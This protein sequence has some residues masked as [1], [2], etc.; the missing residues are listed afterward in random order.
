MVKISVIIP[1]YNNEKYLKEC[2]D[3]VCHQTLTDIEIICINDGSSDG[4]LNILNEY[5]KD[6]R[7][8]VIDQT[9]QG[10]AIARNRGLDIA[11]GEYIGFLD[12]DDIYI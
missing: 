8:I 7:I 6:D 4:S 9:N 2:L 11:K 10:P 1:V 12:S 5:S 3:S